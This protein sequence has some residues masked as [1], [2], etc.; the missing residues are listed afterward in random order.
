M[1]PLLAVLDTPDVTFLFNDWAAVLRVLFIAV[2]GYA[3]LLVL[4]RASGQRTLAKLTSFDLVITI[5]IG[6]AFGRVITAREVAL[7][8]VLAAFGSLVLLQMVVARIWGSMPRLRTLV[9]PTPAILYYGGELIGRE[10]RR[11]RLREVDLLAAARK[12]GI[13]SLDDVRVILL[14]GDGSLAV[15][16]EAAFGDGGAIREDPELSET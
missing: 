9:T 6:S 13:G 15:V 10:M 12:E 1:I 4:L 3:T 5:T 16:P 11:F 7:V 8:E 14:E 2:A